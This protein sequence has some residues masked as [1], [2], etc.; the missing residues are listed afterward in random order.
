MVGNR[1]TKTT[2]AVYLEDMD[3][4]FGIEGIVVYKGKKGEETINRYFL[5][6]KEG[7]SL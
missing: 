5:V 6:R 4:A 3:A 7:V 1:E 2:P